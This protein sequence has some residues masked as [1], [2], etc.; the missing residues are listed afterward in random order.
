MASLTFRSILA[1]AVA[2]ET[3]AQGVT[4]AFF[5]LSKMYTTWAQVQ[6]LI[7]QC[8][9]EHKEAKRGP[10]PGV[11]RN[12]KSVI[13]SGMETLVD[14]D[15]SVFALSST[16]NEVKDKLKILKA[17]KDAADKADTAEGK[18]DSLAGSLA[19][20]TAVIPECLKQ[21]VAA[22]VADPLVASYITDEM[23]AD[24]FEQLKAAAT[25]DAE[26]ATIA[27]LE[28]GTAQV[29]TAH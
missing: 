7:E 11:W 26:L 24:L 22:C 2:T 5:N 27:A 10:L 28:T 19:D 12:A 1:D 16:F 17:A 9:A 14:G 15:K 20:K 4:A 13:K 6:P 8:E 29:A 25:A 21:F 23:M 18:A 3:K